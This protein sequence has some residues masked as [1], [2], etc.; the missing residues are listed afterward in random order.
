VAIPISCAL[1]SKLG[2]EVPC[3]FLNLVF[4]TYPNNNNL[5]LFHFEP[6]LEVNQIK[7]IL[8]SFSWITYNLVTLLSLSQSHYSWRTLFIFVILSLAKVARIFSGVKLTYIIWWY[9]TRHGSWSPPL[10]LQLKKQFPKYLISDSVK[11]F[12]NLNC[13]KQW[14]RMDMPKPS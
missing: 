14:E 11:I 1:V 13:I 8:N 2:K 12:T 5:W 4:A 7:K 10:R 9:G 6:F 3:Y